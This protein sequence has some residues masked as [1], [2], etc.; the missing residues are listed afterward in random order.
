MVTSGWS[1]IRKI[2]TLPSAGFTRPTA[3]RPESRGASLEIILRIFHSH[4]DSLET[5]KIITRKVETRF[6]AHS[7]FEACLSG[8]LDHSPVKIVRF[9]VWIAEV[10]DGPLQ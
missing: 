9:A 7:G 4:T 5:E 8:C 6:G 10:H 2:H 1:A 3:S